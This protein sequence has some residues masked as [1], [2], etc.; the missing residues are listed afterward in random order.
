MELFQATSQTSLYFLGQKIINN[1]EFLCR[2]MTCSLRYV[3]FIIAR[4]TWKIFL[5]APDFH[6]S[7]TKHI[8]IT[9]FAP[10]YTRADFWL[11]NST[12]LYVSVL[13]SNVW[14]EILY[15]VILINMILKHI[16]RQS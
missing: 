7:N 6:V 9:S 10:C 13:R 3:I 16:L 5:K 1:Y 11:F 14:E 15:P 12:L 4:E 8:Q 2:K